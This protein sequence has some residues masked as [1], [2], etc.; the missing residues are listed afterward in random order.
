MKAL[1]DFDWAAY[2]HGGATTD[3]GHPLS[4]P[5]VASR[6]SQQIENICHDANCDEYE[7]FLTGSGNFR[8]DVATIKPYKGT[9][10]TDKPHHY[11]R[12][13][14][15]LIK[16]R[17]A[18]L[19][20]GMEADDAVSIEQMKDRSDCHLRMM[21]AE[22]YGEKTEDVYYDYKRFSET[23]L[24]SIDKDLDMV[25]G[26][27]YDWLK[28][29][30]Y[31]VDEVDGIRHFYKQLLTGD[32]VDNIPGLFGVGKSSTL[33]RKLDDMDSELDMYSHLVTQ[34][35]KRFGS[36]WWQF[37]LENAQLLWML[38]EQPDDFPEGE[39]E[40]ILICLEE[41]RQKALEA[42]SKAESINNLE[43]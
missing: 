19:V 4:W 37:L 23:V 7:I 1:I 8:I 40:E 26:W 16:F 30:R 27:H 11:E 21:S 29:E 43:I 15:Y 34:Y 32:T 3:E 41:Q 39:V 13:R 20:E 25:P 28:K 42:S 14:E 12:I 38:R 2:A 31:W 6:I 10:P 35:E 9:R 24:C 33:L 36:Y 18:T 5:L 17:G 22:S